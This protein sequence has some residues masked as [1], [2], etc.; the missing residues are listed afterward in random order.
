MRFQSGPPLFANDIS[1]FALY[2]HVRSVN[3]HESAC[4]KLS[5]YIFSNP[6]LKNALFADDTKSAAN[7]IAGQGSAPFES[8]TDE[9]R[10]RRF[11]PVRI[12]APS[13]FGTVSLTPAVSPYT[14]R[15]PL[16]SEVSLMLPG[17]VSRDE[18]CP[19]SYIR[20][21]ASSS[22]TSLKRPSCSFAGMSI[23]SYHRAG[24]DRNSYVEES[25]WSAGTPGK[26]PNVT[27]IC[28]GLIELPLPVVSD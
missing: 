27:P 20:G 16:S 21:L 17:G 1:A 6:S 26:S 4:S 9:L 18:P 10:R 15:W 25:I 5:W 24:V 7:D 23:P 28:A 12:T 2:G 11:R 3:Q 13:A 14:G 8:D 19:E 22:N